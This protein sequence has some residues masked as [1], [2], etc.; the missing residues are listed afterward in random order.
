[1]DPVLESLDRQIQELQTK[2]MARALDLAD[3]K[4]AKIRELYQRIADTFKELESLGE[5][6]T[7]ERSYALQITG[8]LFEITPD[9]EVLELC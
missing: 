2:R 7:D 3:P 8:T 1:V 4:F 6:I 5:S 9:W